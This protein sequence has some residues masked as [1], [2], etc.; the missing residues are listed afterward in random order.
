MVE[1]LNFNIISGWFQE[2]S[3][4]FE[5]VEELNC[6][7][8]APS[9]FFW[10]DFQVH[11]TGGLADGYEVLRFKAEYGAPRASQTNRPTEGTILSLFRARQK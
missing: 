9:F 3:P 5:I 7:K 8:V 11:R 1:K 2:L 4:N 10:I 6:L